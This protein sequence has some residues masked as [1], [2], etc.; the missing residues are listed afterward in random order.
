MVL[1][2]L[3]YL[4]QNL[5]V[6]LAVSAYSFSSFGLFFSTCHRGLKDSGLVDR[7]VFFI[8]QIWL[9]LTRR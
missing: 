8:H 7:K 6:L 3:L 1:T 4:T 5:N 9:G 2:F